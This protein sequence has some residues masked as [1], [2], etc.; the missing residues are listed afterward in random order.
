MKWLFR[1]LVGAL[2]VILIYMTHSSAEMAR[3]SREMAVAP[4][5]ITSTKPMINF[6]NVRLLY[7]GRYNG[8]GVLLNKGLVITA[9][10]VS[11]GSQSCLDN[12]SGQVGKVLSS[13]A[14][15]DMSIIVYEKG[16]PEKFMDISCDGFEK[17]EIYYAIGWEDGTDLVVNRMIGTGIK[18]TIKIDDSQYDNL[19]ML[20]GR[21]IK[22]MSG[23]PIVNDRGQLVGINN[24]TDETVHRGYSREMRDT[25]FCREEEN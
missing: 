1:I 13:D 25:I 15:L 9:A 6:K 11:E 3:S 16:L 12:N 21:I 24:V 14:N 17:N 18:K 4:A 5:P 2:I 22:G 7:C 10:H 23:G 20:K 8:T 19:A